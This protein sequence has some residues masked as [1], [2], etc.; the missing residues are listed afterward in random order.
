MHSVAAVIERKKN[1]VMAGKGLK[2]NLVS[3]GERTTDEQRMIASMGGKASGEARRLK[4]S[5]REMMVEALE[6]K[7]KHQAYLEQ[8]EKAGYNPKDV[9]QAAVI[10]QGQIQKA[11]LGDTAAYNAIRDIIGEKPVDE[12]RVDVGGNLFNKLQVVDDIV[13]DTDR[14]PHSEDEI[15]E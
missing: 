2:E 14:M 10:T 4:K 12:S 1:D 8:M 3:L 13:D 15:P 5:L 7:E 11:K 9:T 6:K